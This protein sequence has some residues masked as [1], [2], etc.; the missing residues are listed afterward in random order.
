MD[1]LHQVMANLEIDEGKA[2]KGVGAIL[3][4]LRLSLDEGTFTK[5]KQTIRGAESMMGRSLMSG[6]RTGEMAM[7]AGPGALLASLAAAGFEKDDVPRL[8]R[9]VLEFVRPAIGGPNVEK[10]YEQAPALRG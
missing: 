3:M 5:V 2:E 6:G 4:A 9:L 8:A 7:L 10:F 1:L